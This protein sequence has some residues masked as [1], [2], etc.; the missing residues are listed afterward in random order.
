MAVSEH[1]LFKLTALLL[2][3]IDHIGVFVFPDVIWWRIFGRAAAPIF[4]F[5]IGYSRSYRF[6]LTF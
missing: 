5:L 3:F 6:H 4:F 1:D 2:M